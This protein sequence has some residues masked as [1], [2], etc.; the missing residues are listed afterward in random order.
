MQAT[1]FSSG[2]FTGVNYWA[3]SNAIN[4][5][6]DFNAAA[7]EK[8]FELLSNAG[9]THLRVFPLWPVFQLLTALYGPAKVYEY[10]FGE[11]PLPD[12]P[13]GRAG[14]SEQACQK[15]KTFCTLAQKHGLKLIVALITGHMSFRTYCPPAF[16][17][18]NLLCDPEVLK[19]QVRFVKYFVKRFA[20]EP[21][22]L[23][24]D[25]GN[26]PVHLPDCRN[27]PD[28][29]YVW[30]TLIADAVKA[31][32]REHPVISGL[33]NAD[34]ERSA[35]NFKNIAE[36][37]DVHTTHPYHIFQT[38]DDPLC[39]LKP[40]LDLP[41]R[42]RVG[43]DAAQTSGV[44][45]ESNAPAYHKLYRLLAEKAGLGRLAETPNPHVCLTEHPGENGSC[46]LV[47]V[48][49]SNR[50]V[51]TPLHLNGPWQ[52]KRVVCGSSYA[53]GHLQLRANDGIVLE[54]VG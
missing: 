20:G 13:A 12:T 17:G 36:M 32:D 46:Y 21:A 6:S 25:L 35:S 27:D 39:S 10:A 54:L 18:R 30:C 47:A 26:E 2:F 11:A 48:N 1:D 28:A 53:G 45:F 42:C 5:W 22:I 8:D 9:I 29:F 19:W 51:C 33:D 43:E 31:C 7:I 23:E 38:A 41:F 49:Y 4:M 34:I 50:P 16:E 3:S 24:W 40:I 14:V 37:C 15:F 52:V 44:F